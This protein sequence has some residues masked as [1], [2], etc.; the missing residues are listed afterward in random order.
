MAKSHFPAKGE[1]QNW[2]KPYHVN[3]S[4]YP[5]QCVD[6]VVKNWIFYQSLFRYIWKC[7]LFIQYKRFHM[8]NFPTS[9]PITAFYPMVG[10]YPV[11]P[12]KVRNVNNCPQWCSQH[13]W[14]RWHCWHRQCWQWQHKRSTNCCAKW[15]LWQLFLFVLAYIENFYGC[16]V[17]MTS[18]REKEMCL[19]APLPIGQFHFPKWV[20]WLCVV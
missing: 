20:T 8:S 14:H 15:H 11:F 2:L 6:F 5:S 10:M 7:D 12:P 9:Q 16:D 3:H 19:I 17:I 13:W 18:L 4:N 1:I